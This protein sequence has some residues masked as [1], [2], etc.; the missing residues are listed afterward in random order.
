MLLRFKVPI[1]HL[2]F[3]VCRLS[4]SW[5]MATLILHDLLDDLPA[6]RKAVKE[7]KD[8]EQLDVQDRTPLQRAVTTGRLEAARVLVEA[9]ANIHVA[10]LMKWSL[11][12]RACSFG[13]PETVKFLLDLGLPVNQADDYGDT[14]LM[15]VC[16]VDRYSPPD[17]FKAATCARLLVEAKADLSLLNSRG[18]TAMEI[19]LFEEVRLAMVPAP[20]APPA[21]RVPLPERPAEPR[22]A[23]I[24]GRSLVGTATAKSVRRTELLTPA[25][26]ALSSV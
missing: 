2:F 26:A 1:S 24:R 7:T 22:E 12:G 13:D 4:L 25:I 18:K 3:A 23:A 16:Q 6:L 9:K 15:D 10:S 17:V 21:P 20:E 8:I 14:P 5:R 19:C 11:L